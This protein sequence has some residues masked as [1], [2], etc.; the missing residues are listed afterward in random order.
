M[1]LMFSCKNFFSAHRQGYTVSPI[2][3]EIAV[4]DAA[5]EKQPGR[6]PQ[7]RHSRPVTQ[8]ESF[9]RVEILGSKSTL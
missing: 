6:L 9:F 3:A 8:G 7:G 4:H 2:G 1:I 5:V